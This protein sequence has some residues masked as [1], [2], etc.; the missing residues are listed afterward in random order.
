[1]TCLDVVR[2]LSL[3]IAL[4]PA[5]IWSAQSKAPP[6][7]Q[8]FSASSERIFGQCSEFTIAVNAI[9]VETLPVHP[10][11]VKGI[12]GYKNQVLKSLD[13]LKRL[14]ERQMR[15]HAL[16]DEISYAAELSE[17]SHN[18]SDLMSM[19]ETL[20]LPSSNSV[21]SKARSD[22]VKSL[23]LE[24]EVMAVAGGDSLFYVMERADALENS[25]SR[26]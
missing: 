18:L 20:N 13:L 22:W 19:L 1:M 26:Q 4:L 8:E 10:L 2:S 7:K 6:T 25:S 24:Q 5:P 17:V 21:A 14:D 16:A 15:T 11:D 9:R 3:A 23:D 12:S